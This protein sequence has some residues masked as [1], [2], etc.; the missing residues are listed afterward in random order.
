MSWT[1]QPTCRICNQ[2]SGNSPVCLKQECLEAWELIQAGKR[3]LRNA[4]AHEQQLRRF[5]RWQ[6]EAD[7][8]E[9]VP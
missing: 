2:P 7:R 5:E 1:S 6:R 4:S 3:A 9:N 8:R